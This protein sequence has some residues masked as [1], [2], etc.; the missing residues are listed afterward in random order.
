[1]HIQIT[2]LILVIQNN[3]L[4]KCI[5]YLNAL[6]NAIIYIVYINY[7]LLVHIYIYIYIYFFWCPGRLPR[8][9]YPRASPTS[10]VTLLRSSSFE[11]FVQVF[12]PQRVSKD[13][14]DLIFIKL[15]YKAIAYK[16]LASK[17]YQSDM[18]RILNFTDKCWC[19]L[20][21]QVFFH[22][23]GYITFVGHIFWGI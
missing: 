18:T 17:I 9:P 13:C 21:V 15:T 10:T 4:R 16:V 7:Y 2:T 20:A 8:P 3:K 12:Q 1:M 23:S 22:W 14:S 11:T 5:L 6:S 19:S